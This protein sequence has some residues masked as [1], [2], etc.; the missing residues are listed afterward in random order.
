MIGLILAS[1]LGG[2]CHYPQGHKTNNVFIPSSS[3]PSKSRC[4]L[5]IYKNDPSNH[6]PAKNK[7]TNKILACILSQ[8]LQSQESVSSQA[9]KMSTMYKQ[10]SKLVRNVKSV[11]ASLSFPCHLLK[12]NKF[13]FIKAKL[14]ALKIL[15][16]YNKYKEES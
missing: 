1:T 10:M 9:Y 12:F 4:C 6:L 13:L 15:E 11:I 5:R 7:Q 2:K 16:N 3:L 8:Y 14:N